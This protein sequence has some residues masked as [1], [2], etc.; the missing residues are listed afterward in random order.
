MTIT[1]SGRG[2]GPSG[3]GPAWTRHLNPIPQRFC[4]RSTGGS[5]IGHRRRV[6]A[7]VAR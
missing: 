5:V 2:T 6:R 4:Y 7:E 1:S 3:Q